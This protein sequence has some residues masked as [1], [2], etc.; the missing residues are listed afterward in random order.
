VWVVGGGCCGLRE[1]ELLYS[2]NRRDV[3]DDGVF[4]L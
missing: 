4:I 1:N 3:L 2:S